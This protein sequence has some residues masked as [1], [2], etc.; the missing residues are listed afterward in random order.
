MKGFASLCSQEQEIGFVSFPSSYYLTLEMVGFDLGHEEC[1]LQLSIMQTE[2]PRCVRI[3]PCSG[4]S[5][6]SSDHGSSN[7][8]AQIVAACK[9]QRDES[10]C[11]SYSCCLDMSE[12]EV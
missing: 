6:I 10:G 12:F 5:K 8:M 4:I 1:Y 7:T 11:I 3:I 2:D 9:N